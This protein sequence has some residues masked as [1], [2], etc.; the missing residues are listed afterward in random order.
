MSERQREIEPS[1]V[2]E[3]AGDRIKRLTRPGQTVMEDRVPEIE[4]QQHRN[5]L[6]HFNIGTGKAGKQ[7]IARQPGDPDQSPQNER[8]DHPRQGNLE[9]VQDPDQQS[10]G[11]S[12]CGR[13]GNKRLANLEPGLPFDKT[14]T[15][16]NGLSSQIRLSDGEKI[17]TEHKYQAQGQSLVDQRP[18]RRVMPERD[19]LG[20]WKPCQLPL[21]F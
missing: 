17:V 1:V 13:I 15:G 8:Q 11:V 4:L 10:P 6:K 3:K 16:G 18:L 2:Q 5:V 14:E 19:A 12:V 20:F 9:G 7:P 21:P